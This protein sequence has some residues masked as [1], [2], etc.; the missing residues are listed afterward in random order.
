MTGQNDKTDSKSAV[1]R[2]RSPVARIFLAAFGGMLLMGLGF[3]GWLYYGSPDPPA[4]LRPPETRRY[5]I[6]VTSVRHNAM[7]NGVLAWTVDAE[8]VGYSRTDGMAK[9]RKVSAVFYGS[10]ARPFTATAQEGVI[11]TGSRDMELLGE[12][13]ITDEPYVFRTPR[14][15]YSDQAG[16]ISADRAVS[17]TGKQVA[18]TGDSMTYDINTRTTRISGNVK[19]QFFLNEKA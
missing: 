1:K 4:P 13:V 18:V 7:R 2:R 10:S 14:M 12:V 8:S 19:G 6:M 17:L 3:G 5:D 9:I 11:A 15:A 16:S